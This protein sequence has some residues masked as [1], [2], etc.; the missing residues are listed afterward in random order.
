MCTTQQ[1]QRYTARVS[2]PLLDRIDI[3]IEVR[4]CPMP[5]WLARPMARPQR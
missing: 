4:R 1:I 2:G 5:S 3:H